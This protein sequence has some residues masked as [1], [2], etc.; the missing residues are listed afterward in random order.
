MLN[1]KMPSELE[2]MNRLAEEAT[3]FFDNFVAAF[4][5]FDGEVVAR[6]FSHPYLAVDQHGNQSVLDCTKDTARYFQNYLDEYKSSGSESCSYKDL[7]VVPIGKLGALAS[8]TWT[9]RNAEGVKISSW[10]ESYCVLR[11]S[12]QISA[13]ASVDHAA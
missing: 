5:T 1:N 2:V 13:Y 6:L 8:V 3:E 9:L 4:T 11:K 12:G 7:E 10:R